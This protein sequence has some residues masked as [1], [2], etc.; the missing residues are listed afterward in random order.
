M[1]LE[2]LICS[3]ILSIIMN[4]NFYVLAAVHEYSHLCTS[5]T[6]RVELISNIIKSKTISD[7]PLRKY[8]KE[9]LQNLQIAP[10]KSNWFCGRYFKL[11]HKLEDASDI[12]RR[13]WGIRQIIES[14]R[15]RPINI[16][17]A[18]VRVR[19]RSTLRWRLRERLTTCL[20]VYCIIL[21]F[22]PY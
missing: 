5:K 4:I 15:E 19:D 6:T 16:A 1:Q 7:R 12:C 8:L 21:R 3:L 11:A 10:I 9:T 2:R 17:T 20:L 13:N 18:S 22:M 14:V